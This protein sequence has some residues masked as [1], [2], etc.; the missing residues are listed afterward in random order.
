MSSTMVGNGYQQN[1]NTYN[2]QPP[3]D[4]GQNVITSGVVS[5]SDEYRQR[6]REILGS[7]RQKEYNRFLQK[8]GYYDP[9]P[10][11]RPPA[12]EYYGSSTSQPQS[13]QKL[14]EVQKHIES[15]MKELQNQSGE[16]VENTTDEQDGQNKRMHTQANKEKKLSK[17]KD[18]QKNLLVHQR[19]LQTPPWAEHFDMEEIKTTE[20]IG[21]QSNKSIGLSEETGNIDNHPRN[22]NHKI[23]SKVTEVEKKTNRNRHSHE[24]YEPSQPT[25]SESRLRTSNKKDFEDSGGRHRFQYNQTDEVKLNSYQPERQMQEYVT[26]NYENDLYPK[27]HQNGSLPV[28]ESQNGSLPVQ[29]G[30]QNGYYPEKKGQR[31][32]TRESE[33]HLWNNSRRKQYDKNHPWNNQ[34]SQDLSSADFE[35]Q[36]KSQ[37]QHRENKT[38][39]PSRQGDHR[40]SRGHV[41]KGQ[42]CEGHQDLQKYNDQKRGNVSQSQERTIENQS[43]RGQWDK[44]QWDEDQLSKDHLE[45]NQKDEN[46]Q[47]NEKVED[48]FMP[49]G[50]MLRRRKVDPT[51]L[52]AEFLKETR[53]NY[54]ELTMKEQKPS[55]RRMPTPPNGLDIV[56]QDERTRQAREKQR[57]YGQELQK[58]SQ[59]QMLQKIQNNIAV[60]DRTGQQAAIPNQYNQVPPQQHS[61]PPPQQHA[62]P[63]SRNVAPNPPPQSSSPPPP[64][65]QHAQMLPPQQH[66][67]QMRTPQ[68]HHNQMQNFQR[69]HHQATPAGSQSPPPRQRNHPTPHVADQGHYAEFN[70]KQQSPV[71]SRDGHRPPPHPRRYTTPDRLD[72]ARGPP[73]Q[74]GTPTGRSSHRRDDRQTPSYWNGGIPVKS[75]ATTPSTR[76]PST[77]HSNR[78]LTPKDSQENPPDIYLESYRRNPIKDLRQQERNR[79]YKHFLSEEEMK[80]Q[81]KKE[82]LETLRRQ[83]AVQPKYDNYSSSDNHQRYQKNLNNERRD[84]YQ[85]FLSQNGEP[86]YAYTR[87]P[88][89]DLA[90]SR[91]SGGLVG[92]IFGDVQHEKERRQAMEHQRNK[93]YNDLKKK[94]NSRE[95]SNEFNRNPPQFGLP[96]D[97]VKSNEKRRQQENIR[98]REYRDLLEKQ[99]NSR[100]PSH[101]FDRKRPE[102]GLPLDN[103]RSNE[104]HRKQERDRNQEYNDFLKTQNHSPRRFHPPTPEDKQGLPLTQ[105]PYD[106]KKALSE[107]QRNMEYNQ[108]LAKSGLPFDKMS[109]NGSVHQ[110]AV[111]RKENVYHS[112]KEP[113]S[114]QKRYPSKK[115]DR[116]VE[117]RV[118]EEKKNHTRYWNMLNEK[119]KGEVQRRQGDPSM[120]E[121]NMFS[122][123]GKSQEAQ[124]QRVR[125]DAKQNYNNYIDHAFPEGLERGQPSFATRIPLPDSWY[126]AQPPT[127]RRSP[128]RDYR[129]EQ[130]R[131]SDLYA[132]RLE[133]ARANEAMYRRHDH[134]M[135]G[136]RPPPPR[137]EAPYAL[138]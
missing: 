124:R 17:R 4:Q 105:K 53:R 54:N 126:T 18:V 42:R 50:G 90:L 67:S 1:Y 16:E 22:Q 103:R 92:G 8:E 114:P 63:P 82:K 98:N 131:S 116:E 130:E 5:N 112:A 133:Q 35:K 72:W 64:A 77:Q 61:M 2:G 47:G 76:T 14:L 108:Y 85:S 15:Q 66:Q 40:H 115:N 134:E 46:Y 44:T 56:T 94:N 29:E 129:P 101:E 137:Q 127:H 48:D 33:S 27:G 125:E 41:D 26:G 104:M 6:L 89:S 52:R 55:P 74:N 51:T 102:F 65:P 113:R 19:G 95:P 59:Q 43:S 97:N 106:E 21:H 69:E 70:G 87:N 83:P 109:L 12:N 121:K 93:E 81:Q 84:Q 111:S 110:S 39:H 7:Q 3:P 117:H 123:M 34:Y 138:H 135:N 11:S 37:D 13:V 45:K 32:D 28:Q 30:H 68:I 107:R 75:P 79:E 118:E 9:H 78:T 24:R 91:L 80:A 31:S 132:G 73:R 60:I 36:I 38:L 25:Q 96:L 122:D 88:S 20:K 49:F 62:S 58:Q 71:D 86:V 120:D 136:Q 100:Q 10:S 119:K 57:L 23:N 99:S 128:P